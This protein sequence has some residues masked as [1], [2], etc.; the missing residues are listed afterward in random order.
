M[1]ANYTRSVPYMALKKLIVLSLPV[2]ESQKKKTLTFLTK[3]SVIV[4][5]DNYLRT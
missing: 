1:S 3:Q 5:A 2:T 4:S